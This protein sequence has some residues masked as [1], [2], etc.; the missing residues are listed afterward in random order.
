M[1][2]Q[3]ESDPSLL[4]PG[5]Y[6]RVVDRF[7]E[8]KLGELPIRAHDSEIRPLDP[9]ESHTILG[10]HLRQVVRES[11][12]AVTGKERLAHQVA[13]CN[14]V[15]EYLAGEAASELSLAEPARRLLAV[16]PRGK[17]TVRSDRPDTPLALGCL[18]AGTRLDPSLVSQLRKELVSA[19]RVDIL[20][21]FIKWSG[22]R[23]LEDDLRAFT[24]RPATRLRVLTTSYL[25]ATDLKAVDLLASL[26][27]TEIRVSYDTHRTR[28]H[29]KAY[30]FHRES[31]FGTAYVGSANLSRP[32]LTEGLEWT[33][34]ISEYESPHLWD[35]VAATFETY[36]QDGEF[37]VYGPSERERLK[38]ALEQEGRSAEQPEA[39]FF[40]FALRP[41]GFQ[42]EILER[43]EAERMLQGRSRHLVVAAT[44]TGK[45]LIAAFDYHNWCRGK[46]PG[47]G[48]VERPRLLFVAHREELLR[49]SLMAFRSVL[50][51]P[52]FGDLLVGGSSPE[53]LDHLFVSIQSYNSRSLQDLPADRYDYVV[54]DEFHHAAAPS[55]ER[56]LNHV[57]PR[58]LLGLTATPERTD[59][60]DVLRHFGGHLSAQIRLPDAINRK[61][62]SPFQY[63]AVTDVV[64]LKDLQW[65]RGGYRLDQLDQ[66]YTGNDL[67]AG[68]VIDRVR[69]ILLEPRRARGLG[70]CVSI[71]HAQYMAA[72][73]NRHGIPADSLSAETP[74]ADRLEAQARL[75]DRRVNFLF[76]VD[77]YNEGVDIPEIDT[78]LFLR[79]T[80]S[81]TVFL[82]QLGRGLRLFEDKE[83]LSVLDFVG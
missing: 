83:C 59:G 32:A 71:A 13:L 8:R 81:L 54:I 16:W 43:L 31:G 50:R 55:Y 6:E 57:Q 7:V 25:G 76:V 35:R 64:N 10:D 47:T 38:A 40:P 9:N 52:N 39:G 58:V 49:Q 80:E 3:R 79:P 15:I 4:P 65:Q 12:D 19:D 67:R 70:F 75:R 53:Q 24:A 45:T 30:L 82:Q 56:L 23:I 21:S 69:S 73:F 34:K 29:A 18:L 48:P 60:L 14:Q 1:A 2:T 27:N 51:D 61:L 63:F 28:L 77:L 22:I 62:L 11:L 20:C 41:Y 44:G 33:V 46:E 42:Q 5:L 72:Q 68:L 66:V 78:V 17:P 36:W 26:P 74:H 37:A